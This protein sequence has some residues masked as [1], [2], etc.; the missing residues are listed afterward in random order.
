MA[1]IPGL[2]LALWLCACSAPAPL[3]L[4]GT[5]ILPEGAQLPVGARVTVSLEQ[6]STADG[7][8][9]TLAKAELEPDHWPLAFRLSLPPALAQSKGQ[10]VLNAWVTDGSGQLLFVHRV[11]KSRNGR[12]LTD[13]ARIQLVPVG[14]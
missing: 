6:F 12:H 14:R 3:G 13:P 1:R 5:L 7:P 9:H 11:H 4:A 10:Y 2:L 8:V